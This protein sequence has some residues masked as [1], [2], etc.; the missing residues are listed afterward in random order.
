MNIVESTLLE[1]IDK[2]SSLFVFPTDVAASRWADHLLSLRQRQKTSGKTF[3]GD[4]I[5][6]N[7]F[8]AWDTFKQES[9]RSKIQDKKSIPP[10]LRKMF[11]AALI[12]KN[13][14]LVKEGRPP[15]FSSLI[16]P[17]WAH[18]AHSFASWLTAILPQLGMWFKKAAGI[19]I[20]QIDNTIFN[21][22][23]ENDIEKFSADD[24][25]LC[26]LAVQYS[27]FLKENGLFEPAWE[28]P[29]FNDN[30][31]ICFIF[32]SELLIDFNEYRDLLE[33]SEHV[34]IINAQLCE[35][36]CQN[37]CV[38]HYENS[39]SEITDAALYILSLNKNRNVP[40]D[41]ISVSLP[42]SEYYAPYLIRE[43]EN[44]NIPYVNRCGQPLTSYHA[45]QFFSALAECASGGF[46]FKSVAVL[47]LNSHLPW[48]DKVL[49]QNLID[50][51][52]KNN[53]IS[54]WTEGDGDAVSAINVW[55]DAFDHPFGGYEKETRIFFENLKQRINALCHAKSFD[56]IRKQ[57]FAFSNLFFNMENASG[58]TDTI[59]ARCI[60]ELMNLADIEKSFPNILMQNHFTFFI[61]HI[62]EIIYLA[63]QTASGVAI[64]PYRTAAAAV[65]DCH[66]ILGASQEN[67]TTIFSPLA[68]MTKSKK[69]KIGICDNDASLAF[70][71]MHQFN[72]VLPAAFF[73]AEKTFSGYAIP[74]SA[75]NVNVNLASKSH[76]C[77][78]DIFYSNLY[79]QESQ[80]FSSLHC[81]ENIAKTIFPQNIHATQKTGFEEWQRRRK[82][83]EKNIAAL[84][85]GI[86]LFNV[87]R[88]N[89]DAMYVS[90]SSLEPYFQCPLIWFFK[91]IIN[92]EN[93]K[94]ETRL[95]ASEIT[96][97]VFHAVLNLVLDE[98]KLSKKAIEPPVVD[99]GSGKARLPESYRNL[100]AKKIDA[101]F[102]SFPRLPKSEKTEMSMLTARLLQAEKN[103]FNNVLEIFFVEFISFFAGC[104]VY[105]SEA[106][107]TLKKDFYCLNG[108]VD[109]ILTDKQEKAVI[110]DF[111]TKYSLKLSDFF[112]ENGL[113]NFQLPMYLR[114]AES[115]VKKEVNTA[116]YFSIVD[117]S[118]HV[119]FGTV[120][121]TVNG[122]KIPKKAE[123]YIINGDDNFTFIMNEFDKKSE[124]FAKEISNFSASSDAAHILHPRRTTLCNG[125]EF[126]KVCRTIYKILPRQ[127]WNQK[128]NRP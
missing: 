38:F 105:S 30:G 66:I 55:D 118:A 108:I 67:L 81:H 24:R 111:K 99:N 52:I 91:R 112:G 58:E 102:N 40:W 79:Q 41:S 48:K 71:H 53:C 124:Q 45:G 13:S 33:T 96:G 2:D 4:S 44:R 75:F 88:K 68:F 123:K 47:L 76:E 17:E 16:R 22:F 20:L 128:K 36:G 5:A 3:V 11:I 84:T 103:M 119:L 32:F 117:A 74:Y 65:F 80:Y 87:I 18:N 101:V 114:L 14:Q 126:N 100:L 54:S 19:S 125:C 73:C 31:K 107:Y 56:E 27:N 89:N 62:N 35:T 63:Q 78:D 6:M 7:K 77:K 25:D 113:V 95:M 9:I 93:L 106:Y 12:H 10:A 21:Y 37:R 69:T 109:C 42:N 97:T 86:D 82:L 51:G 83:P 43:L 85:S 29:P 39:R 23:S 64:L 50:F 104:N 61:E 15:V 49:I 60:S 72:S 92:L 122:K 46:S 115:T 110:V 26:S 127:S 98:I 57:Y 59:I 116:L 70:I 90:Q 34:K 1:N 94:I 8:I 28:T 120:E 121:N